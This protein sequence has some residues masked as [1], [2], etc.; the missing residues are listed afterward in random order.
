MHEKGL[1]F[2]LAEV[3]AISPYRTLL[4]VSAYIRAE[5]MSKQTLDRQGDSCLEARTGYLLYRAIRKLSL[6]RQG[7]ISRRD[8]RFARVDS[9]LRR[10]SFEDCLDLGGIREQWWRERDGGRCS[11]FDYGPAWKSLAIITRTPW[12][13]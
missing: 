2:R 12:R 13:R 6:S 4:A 1:N 3:R 7:L 10:L 9:T 11:R 8:G 5:G